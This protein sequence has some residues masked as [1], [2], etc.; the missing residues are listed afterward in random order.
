MESTPSQNKYTTL[1]KNTLLF[2]IGTFSS[3]LLVFFLMPFYTYILSTD[4]YGTVD[5]IVQTANLLLPLVS[6][7]IST[8]VVRFALD[9]AEDKSKVFSSGVF[10]LLIAFL[11]F[12]LISPLI[13]L[14]PI[15]SNYAIL[16]VI[17]VL[18]SSLHTLFSQFTKGILRVKLY[19][20]DGV[21]ATI[22]TLL[23]T[24]YLMAALHMGIQGYI[25]AIILSDFLSCI[26]LF[27]VAKLHK[28]I[29]FEFKGLSK[30]MLKYSVPMI[31]TTIFWWITNVSDRFLVSNMLGTAENGLYAV[32]NKI[33]T[34]MVL[35]SGFFL[36]AWQI[37]AVTDEESGR[38]SF[39]SNVFESYG[40]I[41]FIVSSLLIL[42]CKPAISLLVNAKFH[43]AWE[44]MPA[45]VLATTFSCFVSFFG[46]VYMLYKRS[47]HAMW[48]TLVG[49]GVNI[50]LNLYF[51]PHF[52]IQG[53]GIS[54]FISFALVFVIRVI[55]ERSFLGFEWDKVKFG[56]NTALV[57]AQ[58]V[59][60]VLD[61][62]FWMY[63]S[64]A[65]FI[66]VIVVNY[67]SIISIK[68]R[69]IRNDE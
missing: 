13:N 26:F 55:D 30:L 48:T 28:Y 5:L 43:G 41:L 24:I 42:T 3:K 51:I 68:S 1:I 7:G 60:M 23:F 32:S 29:T 18:T 14:I 2:G 54:T 34:I 10:V 20:I 53:A 22:T 6:L 59:I 63:I 52:G 45:L 66:G 67:R 36:D 57:I 12:L 21:L 11:A 16:L 19:T 33:P 8:S 46:S 49:A 62:P 31:P 40:S 27:V 17:Y 15:I 47:T 35:V 25:L 50:L 37:G 58:A 64:I 4:Q 9:K 56:I 65:L 61:I 44:F 38:K 69:F 39:F